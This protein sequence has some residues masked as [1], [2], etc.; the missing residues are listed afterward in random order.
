MRGLYRFRAA[1]A[2][3][4]G[5]QPPRATI[6]AGGSIMQQALAGA[7]HA[8]RASASRPRSGAPPRTSC[9]ATRRSRSSA[10]TCSTPASRRACRSS[11]AAGRGR[12]AW[13]HRR[14][15][16]LDPAVPDMIAR[17]VPGTLGSLGTDGFGRSD[18]RAALRRF[19]GI[20]AAHIVARRWPSWPAAA[21]WM[22]PRPARPGRAWASTRR[23]PVPAG[24]WIDRV[25]RMAWRPCVSEAAPGRCWRC[26][27]AQALAGA[28]PFHQRSLPVAPA[29]GRL[30]RGRGGGRGALVRPGP[31]ARAPADAPP[32]DR[33]SGAGL[34]RLLPVVGLL[35]WAWVLRDG[36]RARAQRRGRGSLFLWV[37]GWVGLALVSAL[38][39]PAL[40]VAR[41]V[42][43]LAA[44][45]AARAAW[46]SR[47]APA[48]YPR[49]GRWPAVAGLAF[50]IWLELAVTG[51]GG[52]RELGL[53]LVGYTAVTLAACSS[54]A[55]GHGAGRGRPSASGSSSWDASRRSPWTGRRR[56][57]G[58]A[59]AAT[60]AASSGA[61][62]RPRSGARG[63]GGGRRHLR[64]P[65]ADE[66]L[67]PGLR[68]SQHGQ[69]DGPAGRLRDGHRA[70]WPCS[71][72]GSPDGR[73]S[74]PASC[75]SPWAT[76]W[77]TT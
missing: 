38:I 40:E 19:F 16:R 49:L 21:D 42:H 64:R 66:R 13:S 33:P 69:H 11:P 65:V 59:S 30:P 54:M 9:C 77:P 57:A 50:F 22:Q 71:P 70:R 53:G 61:C 67:V 18:S 26:W 14:G 34:A 75:R 72:A 25:R 58:S 39:G 51:G 63:P 62:G 55:A 76:S 68:R 12:R 32:G 56:R 37:Y 2:L 60:R 3:P 8:R 28:G 6:L 41:P 27:R 36:P 74:G 29:A 52:G 35:G 31:G 17:W 10:G 46:G 45:A 47:P 24:R 5:A 1:P 20:D 23:R 7:D 73:P 44:P 43:S 15:Q 48:T 4:R